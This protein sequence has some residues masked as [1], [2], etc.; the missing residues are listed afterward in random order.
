ML[1]AE[2]LDV[3]KSNWK[4]YIDDGS[5]IELYLNTEHLDYIDKIKSNAKYIGQYHRK[6]GYEIRECYNT[7]CFC[8]KVLIQL[9]LDTRD[10][11]YLDYVQYQVWE[12]GYVL[13]PISWT[14]GNPKDF[15]NNIINVGRMKYVEYS[16]RSYGEPKLTRPKELKGI[17]G[18]GSAE[19]IAKK[20]N[21]QVFVEGNNVWI[22]HTD[23]F[24]SIWRPPVGE[25]IDMPLSYYLKKYFG[26]IK[27]KKFVYSDSWGSI[28]LRNEAWIRLDNLVPM[29]KYKEMNYT[30]I[31]REILQQQKF[32]VS[33]MTD[34]VCL[35]WERYWE[36][37]VKLV[38][39]NV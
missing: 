4:N 13:V 20:C 34:E 5:E 21:T 27:V 31:A 19:F 1:Y 18:I 9:T 24:S 2:N 11:T 25:R 22:K 37:V 10:N 17:K 3:L 12:W 36:R 30:Q 39:K 28:I 14:V 6:N 32:V 16:F 15:Y 26:K 8:G 38:R 23:Y 7:T 29:C 35:E 33:G